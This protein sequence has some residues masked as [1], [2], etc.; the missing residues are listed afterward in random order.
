MQARPTHRKHTEKHQPGDKSL[1]HSL[2]ST[3]QLR[4]HVFKTQKLLFLRSF[5]PQHS[6]Y[7]GN[8]RYAVRTPA[9]R[10]QE[11]LGALL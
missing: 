4:Q 3:N 10:K 8:L 11:V 7:P 6:N 1:S 2:P 5:L 9:R